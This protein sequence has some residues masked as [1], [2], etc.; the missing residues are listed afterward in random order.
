MQIKVKVIEPRV[1]SE[2]EW[3]EM[4]TGIDMEPVSKGR[5]FSGR[6]NKYPV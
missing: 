2:K 1:R 5:A 6:S 3:L 4:I